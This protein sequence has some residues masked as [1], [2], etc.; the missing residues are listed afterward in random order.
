MYNKHP[1]SSLSAGKYVKHVWITF[2]NLNA[3][4]IFMDVLCPVSLGVQGDPKSLL[5]WSARLRSSPSEY[6]ESSGVKE[7][8]V[9]RMVS[10][11]VLED[12]DTYKGVCGQA[13]LLLLFFFRG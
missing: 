2:K 12:M 5:S 8:D 13:A 6:C 7:Q 9:L 1:S 4:N 3:R 10:E 11:E